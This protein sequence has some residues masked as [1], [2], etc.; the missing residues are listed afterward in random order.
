[1]Y[2]KHGKGLYS[3]WAEVINIQ[4]NFQRMHR[5]KICGFH[6]D[7]SSCYRILPG[8]TKAAIDHSK[9]LDVYTKRACMGKNVLAHPNC[10]V[11]HWV[12][13]EKATRGLHVYNWM[14]PVKWTN[15]FSGLND[16]Y[17]T[18]SS[19]LTVTIKTD[20]S[21][22]THSVSLLEVSTRFSPVV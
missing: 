3:V 17:R 6:Q 8:S 15:V 16:K 21:K 9:N 7:F 10:V 14:F 18:A 20:I 22:R 5:H 4:I 13:W 1:M 2:K 11:V 12:N 19:Q